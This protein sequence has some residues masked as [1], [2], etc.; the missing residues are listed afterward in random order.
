MYLYLKLA[1]VL[2]AYSIAMPAT[3][4]VESAQEWA[5]YEGTKVKKQPSTQNDQ[6]VIVQPNPDPINKEQKGLFKPSVEEQLRITKQKDWQE[7][8][9][10][11]MWRL[12]KEGI[13]YCCN[14]GW[15]HKIQ[16]KQWPLSKDD[17]LFFDKRG[18]KIPIRQF[19]KEMAKNVLRV[20]G[21]ITIGKNEAE[22]PSH[23]FL[24]KKI[25][26][27]D[28]PAPAPA[29]VPAHNASSQSFTSP[30]LHSEALDDPQLHKLFDIVYTMEWIEENELKSWPPIPNFEKDDKGNYI[31]Q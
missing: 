7:I 17:I 27:V 12:S 5:P 28:T 6:K 14:I 19:S 10:G 15:G 22:I 16:P 3:A 25:E 9:E 30:R 13:E 11:G 4:M 24:Q 18:I 2:L 23:Q 31:I 20:R 1:V 21:E 29:P 26:R 8:C